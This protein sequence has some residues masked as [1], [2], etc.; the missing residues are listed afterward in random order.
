MQKGSPY[1][2]IVRLAVVTSP[3]FGIFGA[4]PI[5]VFPDIGWQRMLVGFTAVTG[6]TLAFWFINLLLLAGLEQRSFR[7]RTLLRYVLSVALCSALLFLF[8]DL[9]VD[10]IVKHPPE[11]PKPGLL[12]PGAPTRILAPPPLF[13]M[14]LIQSQSINV[15]IL[16]LLELVLLRAKKRAM[17]SENTQLRMANLEA[18]HNQLRQQ[19]HPHFLFNSLSTLRALIRR[20]AGS[21]TEYLDKLSDLLRAATDGSP[22]A[23]ARLETEIE[24]CVTYLEMQQVRFGTA[25]RFSVDVPQQQQQ[26]G[27]VPVYSLQLLVENAVKHNALT[28]KQPLTI[29][30]ESGSDGETVRVRNNRQP[31]PRLEVGKGV[32]LSNLSERYRLLGHDDVQVLA[33]EEEFSVTLKLISHESGDH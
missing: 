10:Y 5:F 2:N 25:L 12:H 14:P 16:V 17:E 7:G 4:T 22:R 30:I 1:R 21:A 11:P 3:L 6:M 15:I 8:S 32:G 33:T 29:R 19:L 23:L 13:V 20:D 9:T 26:Q 18:R 24:I 31:K 27:W 28:E